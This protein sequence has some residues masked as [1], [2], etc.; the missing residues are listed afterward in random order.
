MKRNRRY[1]SLHAEKWNNGCHSG[2]QIG[3]AA[4]QMNQTAADERLARLEQQNQSLQRSVRELSVLTQ[5]AAASSSNES[6]DATIELIVHKCIESLDVQQ[7]D[8]HLYQENSDSKPLRTVFREARSSAEQSPYRLGEQLVGWMLKNQ[9]PLLINDPEGDSRFRTL[10]ETD[11]SIR[12]L[13]SVPLR[14]RGKFLGILSAVNKKSTEGFS[15]DDER[16]LS[17]LASHSAPI[18]H[19]V[20]LIGELRQE[21]NQ[22]AEENS[23]L[24]KEVRSEFSLKKILGS[25]EALNK[26]ISLIEQIRDTSVDVL[27]TGESGTGKE[28]IA[29]TIHYSSPRARK[30]FVALNCAALPENLLESELFGIEKGVATG[31]ER[32]LGQFET[33]HRGT[34][35][36][37]EIGDLSLTAQAKILRV[38]QE[39]QVQRLVGANRPIGW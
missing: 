33:A 31:V 22:L 28:L 12:S 34:I 35:F 2:G 27:I 8:I 32:R 13:L 37:D 25:S 30:P 17:I 19:T 29:K 21:R 5:I 20:Q 3:Q 10:R 15:A 11:P 36:L 16:L 9:K 38:L 6:L 24:W 23:Q 14:F 4:E 39:R 7:G 1:F 18:L 26:V